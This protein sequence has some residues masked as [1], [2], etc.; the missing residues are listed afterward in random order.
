MLNV[1]TKRGCAYR[2]SYCT[3]PYLEGFGLREKDPVKVA[4]ELEIIST[5]HGIKHVFF[6]DSVFN[7]PEK[8]ALEI[9]K[10]IIRRKIKIRWSAYIRPQMQDL[11]ILE[12]MQEAGCK[13]IELG[14]D[15]MAEETLA[16]MNKTLS[17]DE[18]FR[19]CEKCNELNI[20]FCHSLIFGAP[21][22]TEA[23]VKKTV[24]NV[25]LT[26]P[27]A[28]IAFVGIR[29]F[30]NTTLADYAVKSGYLGSLEEIGLEPVFYVDRQVE[31]HIIDYLKE[32]LKRYPKWIIPGI[33]AFDAGFLKNLRD[34][35]K[36]GMSWEM[37]KFT[38]Y[39]KDF[40]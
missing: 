16:S 33:E 29:I 31:T 15:S 39:V 35:N 22:E 28:V 27:T 11:A 32:V 40:Q 34:R 14:T 3:Y 5:E 2:C 36:K 13:S 26:N 10:E 23:T 19:F 17:I 37:K 20:D 4:D 38:E 25:N 21:G 1:Q 9:C 30:P 12:V 8:H 7:Y 18:I 6:V 24:A